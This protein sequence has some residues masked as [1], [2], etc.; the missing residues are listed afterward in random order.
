MI[1]VQ[2]FDA[3]L[4]F[5]ARVQIPGQRFLLRN[6]SPTRKDFKR[7]NYWSK[8]HDDIYNLYGGICSYCASWTPR[9]AVPTDPNYTSVDHYIPKSVSPSLA[10]EWSN[11]RL[12]RARLNSNKDSSLEVVDPFHVQ[13]GWFIIDFTSFLIVPSPSIPELTQERVNLSIDILGLN[14]NDMLEQ[15][16]DVIYRYSIDEIDIAQLILSY[17]FIAAE[18]VRQNFDINFKAEISSLSL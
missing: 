11:Y 17:P 13:N 4:N 15:R 7:H 10:Y 14:D 5:L 12:C 9:R 1:K 18:M 16:L 2:Q 6:P 8:I 3:P